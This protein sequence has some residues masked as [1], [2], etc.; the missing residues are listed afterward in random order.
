[1]KHLRLAVVVLFV[2]GLAVGPGSLR[3]QARRT[4]ILE[5]WISADSLFTAIPKWQSLYEDFEPDSLA[6]RALK[7]WNLDHEVLVFFGSWCGDS[8]R[9]VPRFLKTVDV[10]QNP[11]VRYRL[12]ALNRSKRDDAGLAERYDVSRVPTFIVLENGEE[13]G[14]IVERPR[15]GVER[16]WVGVL[17]EDPEW[18][19]R[20]ERAALAF[21]VVL[22]TFFLPFYIHR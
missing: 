2:A 14:R 12:Y 22:P 15:Y 19:V 18:C 10:I 20:A 5:G 16:D 17:L 1:M 13:L 4:P 3:G 6:V 8:R 7:A 21:R 9:E 11:H